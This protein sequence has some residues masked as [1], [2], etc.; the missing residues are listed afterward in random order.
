V[1]TDIDWQTV[2]RPKDFPT[3]GPRKGVA[4]VQEF[5]QLVGELEEFSEFSPRESTP[6]MTRSSSLA[7]TR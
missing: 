6:P 7:A 5:F 1:H 2:G 4:Q 3:L